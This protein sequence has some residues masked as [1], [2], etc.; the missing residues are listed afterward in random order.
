MTGVDVFNI[1]VAGC[2]PPLLLAHSPVKGLLWAHSFPRLRASGP[3]VHS[4]NSEVTTRGDC[5][6]FPPC[7]SDSY[8]QGVKGDVYKFLKC[9]ILVSLM[10]HY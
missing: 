10:N 8:F 4:T 2:T 9:S 3:Q 6:Y 5:L 1:E 7:T